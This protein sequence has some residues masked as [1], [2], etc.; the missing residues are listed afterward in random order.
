MLISVVVLD[1]VERIVDEVTILRGG[2]VVSAS[3]ETEINVDRI[4][5]AMVGGSNTLHGF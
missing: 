4:V 2:K 3:G 5:N 1:E